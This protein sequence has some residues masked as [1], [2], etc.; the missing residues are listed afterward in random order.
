[1][2]PISLH[3]DPQGTPNPRRRD[4]RVFTNADAV[5]FVRGALEE[6]CL[7]PRRSRIR[8]RIERFRQAPEYPV[9]VLEIPGKYWHPDVYA[10][11]FIADDDLGPCVRFVSFHSSVRLHQ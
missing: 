11:W 3:W 5:G 6:T 4:G 7:R 9:L 1:M 8:R 2:P 10:K